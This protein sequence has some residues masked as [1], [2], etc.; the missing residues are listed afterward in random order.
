M[1]VWTLL[2]IIVNLILF[3]GI[4]SIWLRLRRPPKDDPRLSRGLQLLQSKIS[5][6]EDLSDRT[7]RQVNQLTKLLDSKAHQLKTKFLEAE[8]QV[9]KLQSS[10]DR[11]MEVASIFQDKIPHSEIIERQ[12]TIKHVQAARM[13]HAGHSVEEILA[14]TELPREQVE[15]IA[16]VNKDQLMFDE[17]Q[18][19]AWIED[20]EPGTEEEEWQAAEVPRVEETSGVSV[21]HDHSLLNMN[22]FEMEVPK[23]NFDSLK[24]LGDDFREAC[25]DFEEKTN[26]EAQIGKALEDKVSQVTTKISESDVFQKAKGMT[27][28]IL[29]SVG[30]SLQT[31]SD[32]TIDTEETGAEQSIEKLEYTESIENAVEQ[33]LNEAEVSEP[34]ETPVAEEASQDLA[35]K[36]TARKP[37]RVTKVV[38]S[39]PGINKQNRIVRDVEIKKV[40]FP[41]IDL[42]DNL[43]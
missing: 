18:L 15:F 13:A 23:Q 26:E 1:S 39:E 8:K 41:K 42:S 12:N 31:K 11:S 20:S 40:V 21:D 30:D 7:D 27:N 34:D 33:T 3:V 6:L 24:K 35:L 4:A 10:M 14:S 2:Q 32:I 28:Q 29:Q 5:V 38:P 37:E 9:Q 22:A 36:E 16:K 19:P 43:G 17:S 25:K